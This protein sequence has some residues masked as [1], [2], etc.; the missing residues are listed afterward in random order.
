M[1]LVTATPWQDLE[2]VA[3][4]GTARFTGTPGS[5]VP[6]GLVL[7]RNTGAQYATTVADV[8]GAGGSADI[9][10]EAVEVGAHDNSRANRVAL[11]IDGA[12][13][14]GVDVDV[15]VIEPG[16]SGGQWPTVFCKTPVAGTMR[17]R[18]LYKDPDEELG[19]TIWEIR[20]DQ[21]IDLGTAQRMRTPAP[22]VLTTVLSTSTLPSTPNDGEF[23]QIVEE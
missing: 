12:P 7:N 22:D 4:T 1:R 23:T 20:W 13:P 19:T 18:P 16:L 21:E 3:A 15:T 6:L 8:I 2:A 17:H 10:V 11:T 14:A 9:P 5:A